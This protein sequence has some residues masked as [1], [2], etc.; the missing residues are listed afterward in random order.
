L[1]GAAAA[2]VQ[3]ALGYFV[4]DRAERLVTIEANLN[5]VLSRSPNNA[6]AHYLMCRVKVASNR[7]AEGI[8]ECERALALNPNLAAAHAQIGIAKIFDGHPEETE[9][10]VREALQRQSSRYGCL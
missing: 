2:D 1:L 9:S 3:A 10:Q 5:R 4:D 7:G 6:R 8:A